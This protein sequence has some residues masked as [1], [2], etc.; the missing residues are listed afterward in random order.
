M[1]IVTRQNCFFLCMSGF[2]PFHWPVEACNS[3]KSKLCD[4]KMEM[5]EHTSLP[6]H[7]PPP[8]PPGF[9]CNKGSFMRNLAI[10]QNNNTKCAHSRWQLKWI[11]LSTFVWPF[12][13]HS[14]FS[15]VHL[16]VRLLVAFSFTFHIIFV[17]HSLSLSAL[18]VRVFSQAH[19]H[20]HKHVIYDITR[21]SKE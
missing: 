15:F 3:A 14:S 11:V 19:I 13:H 2:F 20:T 5:N 21:D 18:C 9:L 10:P 7:W 8:P 6:L 16:W 1:S 4:G 12:I 17:D